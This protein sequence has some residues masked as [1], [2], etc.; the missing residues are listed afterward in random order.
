MSPS[1]TARAGGAAPRG[2]RAR[3]ARAVLLGLL[4][5]PVVSVGSPYAE[6][7]GFSNFSWSYVPEGAVIPFLLVLAGNLLARRRGAGL[8][9]GELLVV[10]MMALAANCTAIFLLYFWLAAIVSPH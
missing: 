3:T 7:V 10:F 2:Q 9:A 6:S 1:S 5:A 8:R 4:L